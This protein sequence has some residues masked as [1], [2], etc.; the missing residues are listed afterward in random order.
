MVKDKVNEMYK[1]MTEGE[2]SRTTYA[3]ASV[4][5]KD[6]TKEMWVSSAGKKDMFHQELEEVLN[7]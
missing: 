1:N 2:K 6:G 7:K 5:L 3:C 4:K